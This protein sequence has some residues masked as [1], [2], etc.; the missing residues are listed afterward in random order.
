MKLYLFITEC[1]VDPHIEGP[2][3]D[4][5]ARE[6]AAKRH[7][8]GHGDSDG[9]F[10]LNIAEDGTPST[11]SYSGGFFDGKDDHIG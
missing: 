3:A 2:F 9:I 11:C 10:M 7:K 1:D 4:N 8:R 6:E 5:D